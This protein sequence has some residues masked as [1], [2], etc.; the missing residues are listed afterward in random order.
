M[1]TSKNGGRVFNN[2]NDIGIILGT[3][4]SETRVM[5]HLA[6]LMKSLLVFAR[7]QILSMMFGI[8]TPTIPLIHLHIDFIL[9]KP[10]EIQIIL[11]HSK[12]GNYFYMRGYKSNDIIEISWFFTS[13]MAVKC[14]QVVNTLPIY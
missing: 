4:D 13:R 14:H 11:I 10:L 9:R 2:L 6:I 8:F 3:S 7:H 12:V 5:Q 1:R